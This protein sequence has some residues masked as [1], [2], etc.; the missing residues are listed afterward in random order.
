MRIFTAV[1]KKQSY[2]GD[3]DDGSQK[4]II[5]T[6]IFKT[7]ELEELAEWEYVKNCNDMK[8]LWDSINM[9]DENNS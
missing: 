9:K 6:K 7:F 4:K 5:Q 2:H 8:S 3:K 1:V